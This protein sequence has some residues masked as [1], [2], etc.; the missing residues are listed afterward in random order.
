MSLTFERRTFHRR[1][2]EM[3]DTK[4][5][6][7]ATVEK[8]KGAEVELTVAEAKKLTAAEVYEIMSQRISQERA[9]ETIPT[10]I[11]TGRIKFSRDATGATTVRTWTFS[12]V[13]V[14]D[15]PYDGLGKK[16]PEVAYT[17]EEFKN[18]T[19]EQLGEA[20][21][22]RISPEKAKI[23]MEA[24]LKPNDEGKA[25]LSLSPEEMVRYSYN[26]IS[27]VGIDPIWS[28]GS[29]SGASK[30]VVSIAGVTA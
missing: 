22:E 3:A 13:V 30:Q 20:F 10:L 21:K 19:P 25:V 24:L 7:V 16:N 17:M 5:T 29:G 12:R 28:H 6:T 23:V 14:K 4:V 9:R 18:L 26:R 11:A 2:I 27:V 8:K 15:I 1:N